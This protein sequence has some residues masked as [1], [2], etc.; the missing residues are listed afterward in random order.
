[1]TG[2]GDGPVEA[3]KRPRTRLDVSRRLA[4]IV[5]YRGRADHLARFLP[6]LAAYFAEDKIDRR[7]KVRVLVVE[8]ANTLPFNRGRLN[9]AGF[10]LARPH[11]DYVCFHDVDY[12]P[13][14]A[15]FSYPAE[16]TRLIWH[17]VQNRP[18][19]EGGKPLGVTLDRATFFGA[20]VLF[21]NE[22]FARVNG[23]SNGYW[24]WG[25]EDEE[26]RERCIAEGLG[27]EHRDGRFLALA[28]DHAGFEVDGMP[29]AAHSRNHRRFHARQTRL[30]TEKLHHGDGFS[31][32]D[33]TLVERRSFMQ[34]QPEGRAL[35]VEHIRIDF[36]GET[37]KSQGD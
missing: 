10:S 17:G 4:L 30:G 37:E 28:H 35:P 12:L 31:T 14:W 36:Q 27:I 6:H 33:F 32:L 22:D 7:I 34:S 23:Y 16:P 20:V 18:V 15:D 1:M 21:S 29:S 5:P 13:L 2:P 19:R 9:N 11:C 25:Y 8:Q 24:G 26:L 3:A